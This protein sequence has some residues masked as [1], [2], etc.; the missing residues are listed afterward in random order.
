[1]LSPEVK[2]AVTFIGSGDFHHISSLLIKQF[3][4]PLN[5][6]IFDFHPDWFIFPP[7]FS[8]GSWVNTILK[9]ANIQKVILLGPSSSDLNSAGLFSANLSALKNNRLEIYPYAHGPSSVF[10]RGVPENNSLTA[11]KKLFFRKIRWR[12]LKNQDLRGFFTQLLGGL[13]IKQ[14]YVSIDKDCLKAKYALTNW[15]EGLFELGELLLLLKIIKE[16]LDIVGLDI[17]GD[18]SPANIKGYFKSFLAASDHPGNYSAKD[19]PQGLV[20]SLNQEANL[21]ILDLLLGA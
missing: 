19:K 20:N 1:L 18:Y 15:E 17:T 7:R 5:V 14:A 3:K 10:L 21:K 11:E 2:N 8:C 9:E 12:E 4:F 16:N 6:I 13:K